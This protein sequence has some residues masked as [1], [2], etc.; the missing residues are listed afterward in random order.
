MPTNQMQLLQLISQ[1]SF[2]AFDAGLYLNT[3][4]TDLNALEYY[5]HI[6]CMSQQ[7]AA[8]YNAM[9]GPLT[10]E[11]VRSNNEWTWINEPWPWEGAG[12]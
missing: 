6:N 7:A 11:S 2:A 4:P 10:M 5:N 3:H 12:C 1:L 9:Y 8:E